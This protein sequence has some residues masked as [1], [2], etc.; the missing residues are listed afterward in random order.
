MNNYYSGEIF[1]DA[2]SFDDNKIPTENN[3]SFITTR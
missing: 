2:N 1:R 3:I